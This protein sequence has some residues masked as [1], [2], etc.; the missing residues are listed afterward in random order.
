MELYKNEY[1]VN[2]IVNKVYDQFKKEC[3]KKDFRLEKN[4]VVCYEYYDRRRMY[5]VN[6]K[7]I[8]VMVVDALRSD[9]VFNAIGSDLY[10]KNGCAY[11]RLLILIN[12][13]IGDLNKDN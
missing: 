6:K 3:H 9:D 2:N 11:C 7:I 4:K 10:N 1:I 13:S 12:D 8:K 5:Y